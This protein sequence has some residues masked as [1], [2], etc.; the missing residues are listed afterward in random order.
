LLLNE[1]ELALFLK[2]GSLSLNGLKLD[3]PKVGLGLRDF[4]LLEK[5]TW[6]ETDALYKY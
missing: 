2:S 3:F 1:F 4:L 5:N 6:H